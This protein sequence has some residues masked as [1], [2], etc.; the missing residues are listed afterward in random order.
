[1]TTRPLVVLLAGRSG[2]GKSTFAPYLARRLGGFVFDSDNLF[3][4][5]RR[6]VGE[7]SGLGTAVVSSPVWKESVHPRLVDLLLSLAAC[8]AT[9]GHPVVV[10]SPLTAM[11]ASP[12]RFAAA[13][14]GFD[15]DWRWVVLQA[16]PEICRRR[17]V[18]RGWEMDTLKLADWDNYDQACRALP[19]PDG[20]FIVDTSIVVSWPNMAGGVVRWLDDSR[21]GVGVHE[22]TKSRDRR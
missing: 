8:G 20:A 22:T 2:V 18:E 10:V 5:P 3:D 7:A 11:V 9:P 6:A 13:T 16:E 15:V 21:S 17:I 19:I 12:E 14:D 4:A 1:M